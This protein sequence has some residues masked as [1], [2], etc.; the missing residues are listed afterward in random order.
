TKGDKFN[1]LGYNIL[2]NDEVTIS[3]KD[4]KEAEILLHFYLNDLD[5][6]DD[7]VRKNIYPRFKTS[8]DKS[9]REIGTSSL[10]GRLIG[11]NAMDKKY[12]TKLR[13]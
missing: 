11:I 2:P 12:L 7:Y 4:K 5:K 10:S 13:K 9:M 8:S 6:F 3:S 1:I